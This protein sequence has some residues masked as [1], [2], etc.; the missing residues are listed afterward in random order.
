LA[1]RIETFTI[2]KR[3]AGMPSDSEITPTVWD[4]GGRGDIGE[5]TDTLRGFSSLR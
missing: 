5:I 1:R 3:R 2:G 4:G